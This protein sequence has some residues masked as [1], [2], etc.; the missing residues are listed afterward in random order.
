MPKSITTSYIALIPKKDNPSSFSDFRSISLC[1]F[2]SKVVTKVLA[3][4][5]NSILPDII[6][7]NQVGFV[8]G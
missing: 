8:K 4:R 2:V 7:D 5:L 1:S 6:S 3:I